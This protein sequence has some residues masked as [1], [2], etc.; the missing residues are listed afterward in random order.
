MTNETYPDPVVGILAVGVL[1]AALR[2]R[3][4]TGTGTFIDLS[5]REVTVAMLGEYVVDYSVTAVCP[6]RWAI[7]THTW[8]RRASI[9]VRATICGSLSPSA[10]TTNG[11]GCAALSGNQTLAQDPRFTCVLL[12]RHHQTGHPARSAASWTQEREHYQAMH[13]LQ[14]HGVPAGAVLK[15]GETLVDPHLTAQGF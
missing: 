6:V 4:Q 3:R 10:P 11:A 2:Q 5:Q 8:C 15:G 14:A 1:M 13:L 9:P 7:D 12:H